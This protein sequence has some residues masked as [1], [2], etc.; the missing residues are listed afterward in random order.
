M[1]LI[2]NIQSRISESDSRQVRPIWRILA[3]LLAIVPAYY[4]GQLLV[5]ELVGSF[6]GPESS[7]TA[8]EIAGVIEVAGRLISVALAL[9]IAVTIST[10]LDARH[11]REYGFENSPE[12]WR[13]LIGGIGIGVAAVIGIA[14]YMVARGTGQL[15]VS[16]SGTGSERLLSA[17]A[18]IVVI[19]VFLLVNS[20]LEEFVFRGVFMLNVAEGLQARWTNLLVVSVMAVSVSALVFGLFHIINGPLAIM[21]SAVM[22]IFWGIAYLFTGRLALPLGAHLGGISVSVLSQEQF[23]GFTLPTVVALEPIGEPTLLGSIEIWAIR[24]LVGL[25]LVCL[26]VLTFYGRIGIHERFVFNLK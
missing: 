13:D 21:S 5:F 10:R 17:V 6:I 16:T 24:V 22:G 20:T 4:G 2:R 25:S 14:G 8:V 23:G 9:F 15:V 7:Q 18:A 12:W 19:L 3:V 11:L 26:W 1:T